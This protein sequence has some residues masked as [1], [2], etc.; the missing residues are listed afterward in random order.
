MTPNLHIAVCRQNSR[1]HRLMEQAG[2]IRRLLA[3]V[4][5]NNDGIDQFQTCRRQPRA[6]V[7]SVD[8]RDLSSHAI[9]VENR[10]KYFP[11]LTMHALSAPLRAVYRENI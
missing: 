1:G 9:P 11:L 5:W 6:N 3:D 7:T 2:D 4:E 10:L 8:S